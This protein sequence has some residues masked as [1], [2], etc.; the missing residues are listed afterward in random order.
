MGISPSITVPLSSSFSRL[1]Y[2]SSDSDNDD[3]E[4]RLP[5][6]MGENLDALQERVGS[7]RSLCKIAMQRACAIAIRI[8]PILFFC[9]A[10]GVA[11]YYKSKVYLFNAQENEMSTMLSLIVGVCFESAMLSMA[12]ARKSE[13]MRAVEI[14]SIMALPVASFA[15]GQ[16]E[17]NVPRFSVAYEVLWSVYFATIGAV[18]TA[19][20]TQFMRE[21][22]PNTAREFENNWAAYHPAPNCDLTKLF[23]EPMTVK[24]FVVQNVALEV[25]TGSALMAASA[26]VQD[27]KAGYVC[28]L[29]GALI[30]GIGVGNGAELGLTR[31][32]RIIDKRG[33][34]SY[35][36]RVLRVANWLMGSISGFCAPAVF[37]VSHKRP[38]L[39]FVAGMFI[40]LNNSSK[41]RNFIETGAQR[42][43][44]PTRFI[45]WRF[46]TIT[47]MTGWFAYNTFHSP[48]EVQFAAG[49]AI[50]GLCGS[51]VGKTEIDYLVSRQLEPSLAL[52][53]LQFYTSDSTIWSVLPF[54]IVTQD[55]TRI[56]S[57][58]ISGNSDTIL[59]ADFI[60][61]GS[62]GSSWGL[63]VASDGNPAYTYQAI[64][65]IVSKATQEK[66]TRPS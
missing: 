30:T 31:I 7:A 38:E 22:I 1:D 59:A 65:N 39:R 25:L 18:F 4:L 10:T 26:F 45:G 23:W 21:G 35:F 47:G 3:V 66:I 6:K 55:V 11:L 37:A 19:K 61:Y 9:S 64:S 56:Y 36:K 32:V 52:S 15:T 34:D 42:V 40:G 13:W 24:A 17:L 46:L 53:T 20:F 43:V 62:F 2:E 48:S 63:N 12:R 16:G 33:A 50:F 51:F 14:G 27:G 5:Q 8:F 54:Q 28:L 57:T 29:T 58:D 44:K 60:A 49:A 41:K